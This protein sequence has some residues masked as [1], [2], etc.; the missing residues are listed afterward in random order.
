MWWVSK[1]Y[2][3]RYANLRRIY[4]AVS[5]GNNMGSVGE[6][7]LQVREPVYMGKAEEG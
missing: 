7:I 4:V 2:L 6:G 1:A 3:R 5:N